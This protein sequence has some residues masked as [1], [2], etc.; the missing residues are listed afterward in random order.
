MRRRPAVNHHGGHGGPGSRLNGLLPSC[1]DDEEVHEG[2]HH[3]VDLGDR[4][5]AARSGQLVK[6]AG[7]HLVTSRGAGR[8][9]LGT[10]GLVVGVRLRRSCSVQRSVSRGEQGGPLRHHRF[11]SSD[12]R[13]GGLGTDCGL[14]SPSHKAIPASLEVLDSSATDAG[15]SLEQL[16]ALGGA[17][18]RLDRVILL[19]STPGHLVLGL[20]PLEGGLSLLELKSLWTEGLEVA[21]D[22][23][24]L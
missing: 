6:G 4:L 18:Q 14:A 7:Q 20:D 19:A 24:Y 12:C 17:G 21:V 16:T 22:V 8:H 23:G 5:A 3:T 10:A 1:I 2:T 15:G 11:R 13:S 9:L